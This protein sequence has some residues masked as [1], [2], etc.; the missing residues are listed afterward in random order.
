MVIVLLWRM[1][2]KGFIG[3]HSGGGGGVWK[4]L[5]LHKGAGMLMTT[6]IGN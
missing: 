5:I 6:Y 1:R 3:D 4:V 2:L